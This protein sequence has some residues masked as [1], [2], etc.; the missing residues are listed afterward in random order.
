MSLFVKLLSILRQDNL[1]V[2]RL[3]YSQVGN[4]ANHCAVRRWILYP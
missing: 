2:K 4:N 1:K 3:E